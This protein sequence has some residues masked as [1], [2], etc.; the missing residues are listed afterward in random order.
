MDSRSRMRFESR[1][2]AGAPEPSREPRSETGLRSPALPENAERT[3]QG[4]FLRELALHTDGI[5]GVQLWHCLARH[6]VWSYLA[7]RGPEGE[8]AQ[9]LAQRFGAHLAYLNVVL[10]TF[11]VQGW[12][13]WQ[14]GSSV[15]RTRVALSSAGY[16]LS[17]LFQDGVSPG[18]DA[19]AR[20][21]SFLPVARQM[22]RYLFGSH[23]PAPGVPELEALR[24]SNAAGWGL[25]RDPRVDAGVA[26]RLRLGLEGNLLGPVVVALQDEFYPGV[27][28][29]CLERAPRAWRLPGVARWA[30][31]AQR[32]QLFDAFAGAPW[33]DLS[34]LQGNQRRLGVAFQLLADVGWIEL[35]EGRAQLTQK[36]QYASRRAWAYGVPVS[37]LP[38]FGRLDELLFGEHRRVLGQIP[39]RGEVHVDR[40]LNV[41][42]SG[43][44]HGRYFAAADELVLAAFN[45]PFAEQ[46]RGFADMGCGD[47]AWLEHIWQLI[48][49]RSE[50][51][52]LLREHPQRPEYQLLMVGL[53]YNHAARRATRQRLTRAGVP[54]LVS[55]GDVNDPAG[56]RSR[57]SALGVDSRDLLH[58]SS[59]LIHNRPYQAPRDTAQA[60][61]RTDPPAG[62]YA[63]AGVAI[64]P[65]HL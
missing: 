2:P 62:A 14:P 20:V 49:E 64:E 9:L 32:A 15:E 54:H 65:A 56:L 6:G 60:A 1:P 61:R 3:A 44:T 7:E 33:I 12:L 35:E 48:L 47:G 51:G 21:V 53:D 37:Y 43:A 19:A 52:R 23:Q 18:A 5:G 29:A 34:R 41:K 45:R 36:G 50:R 4:Q 38:L 28:G 55:F 40:R 24:D 26:E 58:G 31:R 13:D 25:T 17:R 46:P 39:G 27:L 59:F 8:S 63:A 10:R 11:G 16:E 30:R 57:L 42:A 22:A